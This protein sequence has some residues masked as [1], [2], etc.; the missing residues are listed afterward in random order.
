M[1]IN[2]ATGRTL[3]DGA[4]PPMMRAEATISSD[5]RRG[6]RSSAFANPCKAGFVRNS[7]RAT[8][9]DVLEDARAVRNLRKLRSLLRGRA[10]AAG[11][12]LARRSRD[13][14]RTPHDRRRRRRLDIQNKRSRSVFVRNGEAML[15]CRW[16]RRRNHATVRARQSNRNDAVRKSR[17]RALDAFAW[18]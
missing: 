15:R 6:P 8:S 4:P 10:V 7:G 3:N 11:S 1:A 13:C 12:D 17:G 14:Q 2:A 16:V 5:L 18:S 9:R